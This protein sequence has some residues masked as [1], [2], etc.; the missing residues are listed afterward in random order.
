[1]ARVAI[2]AGPVR[3][4]DDPGPDGEAD[5]DPPIE[6]QVIDPSGPVAGASWARES[7]HPARRRG[8]GVAS[9]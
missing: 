1:V 8:R 3:A 6:A 9:D 4:A 7:P 2:E 5:D